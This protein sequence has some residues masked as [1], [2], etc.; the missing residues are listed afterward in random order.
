LSPSA[1]PVW[2]S[3]AVL[4]GVH[5]VPI[6]R[7][8][9]ARLNRPPEYPCGLLRPDRGLAAVCDVPGSW[10]RYSPIVPQDISAPTRPPATSRIILGLPRPAR[11]VDLEYVA[12]NAARRRVWPSSLTESP[13]RSRLSTHR[14]P[15]NQP[16]SITPPWITDRRT[17][18]PEFP[19]ARTPAVPRLEPGTVLVD[20]V[21][22][23]VTG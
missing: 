11:S 22:P 17:S 21:S 7:A 23:P 4:R 3:A 16:L 20:P 6:R 18:L 8:L 14:V 9:V 15:L 10:Q 19:A 1:G 12:S 2:W 13:E 5:S